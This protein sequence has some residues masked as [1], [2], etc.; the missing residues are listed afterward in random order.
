MLDSS[1]KRL[2]LLC[3]SPHTDD[4][5]LSSGGFISRYN[6]TFDL[7]YVAFCRNPHPSSGLPSDQYFIEANNSLDLLNFPKSSDHRIF[8][9]FEIR[10]LE[11][12]RQQ[13]LQSMIDVRHKISPDIVL[14]PSSSDVHQDHLVVNQEA[15]RCFKNRCTILG[16]ELCWNH[17]QFTNDY[18][19][20]LTLAHI[21]QKMS[22]L[23]CYKSQEKK[24]YFSREFQLSLARVRGL[25]AGTD[26]AECFELIRS[27]LSL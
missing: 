12:N 2:K 22:A 5:E 18:Y 10:S 8:L 20:E 11:A 24:S 21:E 19:V 1:S 15:K 6:K 16:Y 3:L 25:Q 23:S 13:V 4:I 7:Y 9:D 26:Y 17:Y 27:F 14:C